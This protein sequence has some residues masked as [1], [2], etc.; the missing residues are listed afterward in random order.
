M[1]VL[2]LNVN[3]TSGSTGKIVTDIKSVLETNGHE[4]IIC[5]GANDNISEKGYRRI[6]YEFERRI[7]AGISRITGILHGK[8]LPF[9]FWRLKKLVKEWQPDI[10]HIH[11]PNGYI[12]DI[13][14]T[15]DFLAKSKIKTVLTNHAEFFYTGGCGHAY[16]CEKWLVGCNRCSRL[17]S[18]LGLDVSKIEWTGFKKV[19]DLF[20]SNNLVV[21][22]VSP[23]VMHRATKSNTI[24]RFNNVVVLNG[25]DTEVFRIRNVSENVKGRLPKANP[26]VLH[27]TASFSLEKES[28]KGGYWIVELA[29]RMPEINFIIVCSYYHN[30][31]PL[32]KNVIIWGRTE[33]Q[34]EL[35]ELYNAADITVITSKRETFSMIVAESL[36]CGTPVVGFEAGGPES[37]A[38]PEFTKFIHNNISV[39][40]NEI[41]RW[42]ND[43]KIH[44]QK[45]NI[46]SKAKKKYSKE[47]MSTHYIEVY[48]NL[49]THYDESKF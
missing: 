38:I 49:Y 33:T 12:I 28:I 19:F 20:D 16:D 9:S 8:F 22:S 14:K 5:Y 18:R 47:A 10:V 4:C 6:C 21:T 41:I 40:K 34:I 30:T 46:A 48:K 35:A 42:V 24:K 37:I 3:G 13:F 43:E 15:L 36:C 2:L 44:E 7:N 26:I 25:V 17:K 39:L 45:A 27:V 29:K 1:K 11:C 32:P 23:W 31:K